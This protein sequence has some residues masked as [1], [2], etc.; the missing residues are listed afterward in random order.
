[1]DPDRLHARA[2]EQRAN[3]IVYGIVRILFQP[4]LMVDVQIAQVRSGEIATLQI[5]PHFPIKAF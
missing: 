1:M 3:P 2:R 5:I 4:D